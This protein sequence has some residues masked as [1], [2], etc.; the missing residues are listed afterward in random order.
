MKRWMLTL[1]AAAALAALQG[2]DMRVVDTP[3]PQAG[4]PSSTQEQAAAPVPADSTTPAVDS[5]A[6][7]PAQQPAAPVDA[8]ASANAPMP[9]DAGAG[10]AP[11]PQSAAVPLPGDTSAPGAT[12]AMGAPAAPI[13]GAAG[14]AAP[15][16]MSQ[17]VT[18][19][20]TPVG[21]AAQPQSAGQEAKK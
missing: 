8:Q 10:A 1:S 2:C 3:E 6:S 20:G 21:G 19:S 9:A 17:F 16:E 11:D 15:T 14:S 7:V 4:T 5:Q 13:A 18:S 12:A